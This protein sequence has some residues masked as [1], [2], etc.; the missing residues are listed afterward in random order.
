MKERYQLRHAAGAYW[1]LDMEQ[2]QQYKNPFMLNECGANIYRA[3]V[4]GMS[5]DEII[6]AFVKEYEITVSCAQ[7][8]VKQFMAELRQQGII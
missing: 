8:D 4:S 6:Q 3:C 2:G 5:E 7:S 1:L